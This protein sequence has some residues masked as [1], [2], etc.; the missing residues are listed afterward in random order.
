MQRMKYLFNY[1]FLYLFI[2]LSYSN[3][4]YN[5]IYAQVIPEPKIQ[6]SPKQ[7]VCYRTET[8]LSID[9]K[10]DEAS[11]QKASWT[12]LFA[13]IEGGSKPSPRFKTRA[14]MLWDDKYLYIAA[15]LEEPDVWATL[16]QRDTLI[17]NDNAFEIFVDPDGDTQNYY[18][19]EINALNTVWD[20]LMTKP[21]RM[22]GSSVS[23]WDIQGL[24]TGVDVQGTLNNPKDKD[25]G[26][27]VEIAFPWK[28]ITQCAG[29]RGLPENGEQWRLNLARVEW[30]AGRSGNQYEKNGKWPEYWLWSP[31]GIFDMHYPEM[32]GYVQFS[33]S[34]AGASQESFI[35]RPAEY[36]KW[37]LRQIFY[38]EK[39]Y[40]SEHGRYT[41]GLNDL[42][43]GTMDVPGYKWP[44]VIETTSTYFEISIMSS[45]K[46]NQIFISND[47][48]I[49][50]K[51]L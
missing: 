44:A 14:K 8:G 36:A 43:I 33:K 2:C 13:D 40:Y 25:Q 1:I 42:K 16:R 49:R 23:A 34:V 48:K 24:Q 41:T 17:Y 10:L 32:W 29:H 12:E 39:S 50:E 7:Y 21:Y 11:W 9:G 27:T 18:E 37:V 30:N 22:G 26:W 51:T 28:V 47:G 31:H 38:K 35:Q 4:V 15:E 45:D 6:F 19:F 5:T 3:S 20:L 46:K